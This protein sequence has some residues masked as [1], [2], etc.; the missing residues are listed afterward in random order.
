MKMKYCIA[1]PL[2]FVLSLLLTACTTLPPA[3]ALPTSTPDVSSD[4]SSTSSDSLLYGPAETVGDLIVKA[5][6]VE[7]TLE[8][9]GDQSVRLTESVGDETRAT[10]NEFQANNEKTIQLLSEEYQDNLEVTIDSLDAGTQAILRNIDESLTT[11]NTLLQDN[12]TLATQSS[13]EVIEAANRELQESVALLE[14]SVGNT[15]VLAGETT[16]YVI[17]RA[18]NDALAILSVLMLGIGAL[19]CIY[20]FFR[21]KVPFGWARYVAFAIMVIYMVFFLILAL[22]PE[23]R[24]FVISHVL[25]SPQT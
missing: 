14:Q 5:T 1:L 15:V 10:L 12:V 18:S 7:G 9:I 23:A 8:E 6:G 22:S 16:A 13:I 17:D 25:S 3:T 2:I 20:L 11:V 4:T 21:H 19:L 24:A